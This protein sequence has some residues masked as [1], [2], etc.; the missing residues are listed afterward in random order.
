MPGLD[1]TVLCVDRG[2]PRLDKSERLA[3]VVPEHVVDM[4]LAGFGWLVRNSLFLRD[5]VG[6]GAV[7]AD[8]PAGLDQHGVDQTTTG[9]LLVEVELVDRR[10]IARRQFLLQ[11]RSLCLSHRLGVASSCQLVQG[12]PEARFLRRELLERLPLLALELTFVSSCAG[13]GCR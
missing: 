7:G 10:G 13:R 1:L 8:V 6:V 5:L 11:P 2:S 4:A 3:I 12:L 9:R